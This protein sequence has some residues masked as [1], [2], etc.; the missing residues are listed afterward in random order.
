MG[1][2]MV[3]IQLQL[4]GLIRRELGVCLM[5]IVLTQRLIFPFPLMAGGCSAPI[6]LRYTW[7]TGGEN[8]IKP[9]WRI[10]LF[11]LCHF[12][13]KWLH[14][15]GLSSYSLCNL[16]VAE[17]TWNPDVSQSIPACLEPRAGLG[18]PLLNV[19]LGESKYT[20]IWHIDIDRYKNKNILKDEYSLL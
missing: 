10:A 15:L 20:L 18:P 2:N 11:W 17:F 7:N 16:G 19:Q 1:Y 9:S 12:E 8:S 14:P 3:F 5:G 13:G 6:L 4:P